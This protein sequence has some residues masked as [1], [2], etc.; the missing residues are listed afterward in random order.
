[1]YYVLLRLVSLSLVFTISVKSAIIFGQRF[2]GLPLKNM[3]IFRF[4]NFS[5]LGGDAFL[6][7]QVESNVPESDQIMICVSY[8]DYYFL[9]T[10][11]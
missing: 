8:M 4:S 2:C 10:L 5:K 6:M 1:M 3:S 11:S 7:G 9:I